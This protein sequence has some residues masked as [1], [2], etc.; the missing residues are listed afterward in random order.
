[1]INQKQK[2][3]LI[4]SNPRKVKSF[5]IVAFL[6][7]C[8][9]LISLFIAGISDF[10]KVYGKEP[11]NK[12]SSLAKPDPEEEDFVHVNATKVVKID[13]KAGTAY[14]EE[15]VKV[16]Q[17]STKSTL[18]SDFLYFKRNN[19]TSK[20]IH[21]KAEGNVKG[22]YNKFDLLKQLVRRVNLSCDF[23]ELDRTINKAVLKGK[24]HIKSHDFELTA[25]VVNYDLEKESGIITEL[26]GK[27]VKIKVIKN[28][29]IDGY[30]ARKK[31]EKDKTT[32]KKTNQDEK[33]SDAVDLIKDQLV[34]GPEIVDGAADEIRVNRILR[35]VT[36]QGK[37]TVI[38]HAEQATFKSK[39]ADAYFD[40]NDE[41]ERIIAY[42]DVVI[43]QPKRI[44]SSDR[45]DFD[46]NTET[47]TL[48]GNA[49]VQEIGQLQM[50]SSTIK[51][52]MDEDKGIISG[53]KQVPVKA[54]IKIKP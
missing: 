19:E 3:K 54:K 44:A 28:A 18:T 15:N 27:Q 36:L 45:A 47:V 34:V 46:Y 53:A 41:L 35:K 11:V 6:S 23:A 16:V 37:V 7:L 13:K 40:V 25:D 1:M 10:T 33:N 38:D 51:M 39:K 50:E 21:G 30:K 31:P 20:L 12:E 4:R 42:G 22:L 32:A 26:P 49:A 14:L 8:L 9:L 2:F 29:T 52:H 17:E 48:T 5:D 43:T 24:V